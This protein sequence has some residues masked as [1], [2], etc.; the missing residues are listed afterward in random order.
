MK[1]YIDDQPQKQ[2]KFV[3]G[4]KLP[5]LMSN[6][7]PNSNEFILLGV[8]TEN[9]HKVITNNNIKEKFYNSILPPSKYLPTFWKELIDAK[10]WKTKSNK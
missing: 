6:G 10:H 8:N 9:E 7:L 4:S 3:P 5:I 1:G 2:N